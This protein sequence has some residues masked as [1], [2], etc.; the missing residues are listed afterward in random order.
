MN[1]SYKWNIVPYRNLTTALYFGTVLS[2]II[3]AAGCDTKCRECFNRSFGDACISDEHPGEFSDYCSKINFNIMSDE[4]SF[5]SY[6]IYS[7]SRSMQ[8]FKIE[9]PSP[10]LLS[11]FV[12]VRRTKIFDLT[13]G[14]KDTLLFITRYVTCPFELSKLITKH[15]TWSGVLIKPRSSWSC[16]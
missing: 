16:H 11:R 7:P 9:I 4:F 1:T 12:S 2:R 15:V 3:P 6:A 10:D 8:C 5:T 13:Q 14:R